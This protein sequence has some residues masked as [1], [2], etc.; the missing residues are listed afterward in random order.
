MYNFTPFNSLV[1]GFIIGASIVLY[2]YTTGRLAGI[3]GILANT[4]TNKLNRASNFL[5]ILGLIIG[6]LIYFFFNKSSV[7]FEITNSFILIILGGFFVGLGTKMGGGCTSGHGICG[8]SRFSIRSI[9]P[10]IIFIITAIIT[11]FILQQSG[12]H[13]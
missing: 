11:V 5:F 4:V 3:S 9:I 13:L 2:F 12:I 1:G 8:I 7:N 6:P 10:T